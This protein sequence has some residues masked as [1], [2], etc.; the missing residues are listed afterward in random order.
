MFFC[1]GETNLKKAERITSKKRSEI[2]QKSGI[3][4]WAHKIGV[5][6]WRKKIRCHA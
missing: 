5:N 2:S 1:Y 3:T 4:L 6:L